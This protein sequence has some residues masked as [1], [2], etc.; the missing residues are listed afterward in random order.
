[1]GGETITVWKS[2]RSPVARAGSASRS[3]RS[4]C[5]VRRE[6]AARPAE[7]RQRLATLEVRATGPPT[8]RER[9][10]RLR[11]AQSGVHRSDTRAHSRRTACVDCGEADLRC[12]TRVR[13]TAE[14]SDKSRRRRDAAQQGVAWLGCAM[15]SPR[16]RALRQAVTA[17]DSRTG[18]ELAVCRSGAERRSDLVAASSARHVA[19]I[20]PQD[21]RSSKR[22]LAQRECRRRQSSL[23]AHITTILHPREIVPARL[24]RAGTASFPASRGDPASLVERAHRPLALRVQYP[25]LA[26]WS[27]R[28]TT[29]RRRPHAV[30]RTRRMRRPPAR[31]LLPATGSQPSGRRSTRGTSRP[32]ASTATAGSRPLDDRTTPVPRGG[33][34]DLHPRP[35]RPD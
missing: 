14:P 12:H 22:P 6:T 28:A 15:R 11:H 2:R 26:A 7:S 19:T 5:G 27:D 1:V 33:H 4:T 23:V 20:A 29:S 30:P 25:A 24:A 3:R 10:R 17:G 9:E 35:V 21:R 18:S 16:R 31:E 34:G 8:W 13:R 32:P